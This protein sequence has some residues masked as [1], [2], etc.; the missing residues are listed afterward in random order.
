LQ[1]AKVNISG[2]ALVPFPLTPEILLIGGGRMGSALVK[3]WLHSS[4]FSP[5]KILV[6]EPEE[7]RRKALEGL[8]LRVL[9]DLSIYDHSFA[10]LVLLWAVK[11]QIL[12]SL[13]QKWGKGFS[14]ST[15]ISI[16][17]GVSVQALR[18]SLP[19]EVPLV[20]AMPN[21][22]AVVGKGVTALYSD[23]P[24]PPESKD[25][26]VSLFR[27][28][29]EVLWVEKESDLHIVTALSGSGP[30]YVALFAEALEDAGVL[31][32][33]SR[34]VARTLSLSTLL[35][36][37]EQMIQEGLSPASLKERVMSPGGTTARGLFALEKKGVRGAV[38]ASVRAAWE[39]SWEIEEEIKG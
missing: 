35:G 37:A 23:S 30:A 17:A 28:V 7:S 25:R 16:A 20:R 14:T 3:G 12:L 33:L 10:P 24:L 6:I 8:G 26:I 38:I 15:H 1:I 5:Q 19:G 34:E 13:V 36:S 18:E 9:P 11:P 31:L 2:T 22:P 27:A 39:R 4:L 32:G 21:Q 29:G